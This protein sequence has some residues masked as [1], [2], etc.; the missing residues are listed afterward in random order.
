MKQ[1]RFSDSYLNQGYCLYR[2]RES[3]SRTALTS[4]QLPD[5]T[6][7][8]IWITTATATIG[9][10]WARGAGE[11]IRVCCCPVTADS[12]WFIVPADSKHNARLF[13]R[14][15]T[16]ILG[17]RPGQRQARRLS[18]FDID[19]GVELDFHEPLLSGL[20]TAG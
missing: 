10:A 4:T 6:K 16:P 1:P 19:V 7:L 3:R 18:A 9:V 17:F 20:E 8:T 5:N 13:H 14:A 12:P 2:S 11:P 15:V